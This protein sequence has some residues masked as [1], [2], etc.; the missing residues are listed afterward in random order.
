[1][2]NHRSGN[3]T[4][5]DAIQRGDADDR[6]DICGT[7]VDVAQVICVM[8]SPTGDADG[9]AN[10]VYICARCAAVIIEVATGF[11]APKSLESWY[12]VRRYHATHKGGGTLTGL[13]LEEP[14]E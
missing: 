7:G 10:L 11:K 8:E 13:G 5:G 1:M 14:P 2:G 6:C 4:I 3:L 12:T 9:L